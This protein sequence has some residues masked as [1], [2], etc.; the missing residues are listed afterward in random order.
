[1]RL[2]HLHF[3][4]PYSGFC[5]FDWERCDGYNDCRDRSDEQNCAEECTEHQVCIQSKIFF[6]L[7]F[8]IDKLWIQKLGGWG[9]SSFSVSVYLFGVRPDGA[10]QET[11]CSGYFVCDRDSDCPNGSDEKNCT[12]TCPEGKFVCKTGWHCLPHG[13]VFSRAIVRAEQLNWSLWCPSVLSFGWIR[14]DIYKKV[15]FSK[16]HQI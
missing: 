3:R 1:M 15:R 6:F 5:L 8:L 2:K 4:W 12:Y 13:S 16:F 9:Y 10:S 11:M 14:V 7:L